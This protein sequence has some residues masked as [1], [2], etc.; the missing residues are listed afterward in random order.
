MKQFAALYSELDA[1]TST[2][3][4]IAALQGYLAQASALS[5]AGRTS[6]L[7]LPPAKK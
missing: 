5:S 2:A 6:C 3:A 7:G 1:S 4:K